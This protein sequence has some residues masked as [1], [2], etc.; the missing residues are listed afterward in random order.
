MGRNANIRI[1]P[2]SC[3]GVVGT[4]STSCPFSSGIPISQRYLNTQDI[5]LV[6]I[7]AL[8]IGKIDHA[9]D[10]GLNERLWQCNIA[11]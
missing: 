8:K 7:R 1:L 9:V 11:M 4:F 6:G 5:R 3:G 10:L 2:H